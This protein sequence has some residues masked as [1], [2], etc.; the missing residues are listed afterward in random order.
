MTDFFISHASEDKL[1][2]A[3]PLADALR[4]HGHEVWY[5][6]YTLRLGDSLPQEID[7]G[8]AICHYGVVILSAAFFS[9]QWP[10]R[11]L[12]G[13]VAREIN[14]GSKRILPVWHEIDRNGVAHFS[15]TLASRLA[16][17]TERGLPEVVRQIES[18]LEPPMD[19]PR[20]AGATAS[21]AR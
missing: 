15:P 14:E 18:A 8:L 17:S 13:L 10:R 9:K 20:D 3:R 2:I 21:A 19:Q 5:D 11:E 4:A 7:R 1:A 6:E 16:V 12:D